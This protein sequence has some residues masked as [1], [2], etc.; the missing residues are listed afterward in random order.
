MKRRLQSRLPYGDVF[1]SETGPNV[2]KCEVVVGGGVLECITLT[3]VP[4]ILPSSCMLMSC[5]SFIKVEFMAE[6]LH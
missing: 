1:P 4:N 6:L 3:G 2:V 5:I